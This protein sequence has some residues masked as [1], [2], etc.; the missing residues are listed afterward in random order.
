MNICFFTGTRAD[1]GILAPIM[2]EVEKHNGVNLQIIA[3]N[4]H[5]SEEFGMTVNEIEADGFK[6]A[7]KIRSLVPG[8]N[9]KS[10]VLSIAKLEEGL[11]DAYENLRP[12]LLVILGDRYEALAAATAAVTFNIPIA[13]LHGG[14]TTLGAIDDK[15][16][17]A[18]TKLADYHFAATPQYV[19]N[20][21]LMGENP[22]NVFHS[23]APGAVIQEEE[24]EDLSNVFYEK[25]ELDITS[26]QIILLTFHPVTTLPDKGEKELKATLEALE[27]FLPQGYK[28]LVSM[29]NSDPGNPGIREMLQNWSKAHPNNVKSV[30]SLGAKLFHYAMDNSAAIV[31]NSSAAL[32]E[33][34]SHRLGAVNVGKR[35][36][37]RAHGITVIDAS[38]NKD[39]IV[40][41]LKNVLSLEMKSVLLGLPLSSLN[42]YYKENAAEFIAH[43]LIN[44]TTHLIEG[45]KS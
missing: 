6:V 9:A 15:F 39:S 16:R 24:M 28:V 11:A 43:K 30:D 41:A 18:I 22:E 35:Q 29:P 19:E 37:G 20:I 45:K 25:T 32:I 1:Y 27:V 14:E 17:H 7:F 10:T 12:D 34:P 23:G 21:I 42:P 38:D 4:M 31:G 44:I 33:A 26:E 5:L 2:R 3:A 13:H 36:L 8:G 40:S